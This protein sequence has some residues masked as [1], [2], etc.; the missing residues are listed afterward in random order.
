MLSG[1][2]ERIL[3]HKNLR[4]GYWQYLIPTVRRATQ[5]TAEATLDVLLPVFED[6]IISRR[7]DVVWPARRC[8]LIPL[9]YYLRGAIK[10][11]CYADKPETINALKDNNH[12]AIGEIQPHTIDNVLKNYTD[13]V[14]Y[15]ACPAEAVI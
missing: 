15:T 9:H 12:E 10:V 1:H 6:R 14:A 11:K 3:V 8:D 5:N 13:R 2:V 4:A 7:A